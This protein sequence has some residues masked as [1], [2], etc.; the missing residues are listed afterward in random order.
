MMQRWTSGIRGLNHGSAARLN[1]PCRR[2][3]DRYPPESGLV[4]LI[5]SFVGPDPK[6]TAYP[7][8]NRQMVVLQ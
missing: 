3:F 5:V 1:I 7:C 2:L 8:S 6:R 4:M